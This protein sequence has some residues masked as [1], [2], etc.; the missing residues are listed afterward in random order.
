MCLTEIKRGQSV[1]VDRIEDEELRTQ[2]IRF[3]I[4]EGSLIRCIERI[5]FGPFMVRH[6][7]QEIAI[8]RRVA[9]KIQVQGGTR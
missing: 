4:G 5:P 8:G 2:L 6:N 9:E 1:R 3:G 7:R